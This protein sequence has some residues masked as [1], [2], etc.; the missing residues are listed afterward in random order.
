[1]RSSDDL[2]LHSN[3]S[4]E[5]DENEQHQD[6]S[7]RNAKKVRSSRACI[8]CRRMKT[9]CEIDEALGTA[10]KL[11]I[12]A[13]RQCIMQSIPRRR[14]RKTT[15]R[16]A[17]LEQ[18]INTLTALLATNDPSA[19][20][21]TTP[22]SAG[23]ASSIAIKAAG[24]D[25]S[26]AA[27]IDDAMQLGFLDWNRACKAF[28]WY[29]ENMSH[30]LP[31]VVFPATADAN[32]VKEQQPLLFFAIVTVALTAMP[33]HVNA[34]LC[35]MLTKELAL[36]IVYRGERSLELVQTLL[37]HCTWY[38]RAKNMR[39]LNFNQLAHIAC[40]MALDIGLGRRSHKGSST[41]PADPH[42][43]ESLTGRR[44]WLGCYYMGTR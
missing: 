11:C 43:L 36:R 10:C 32:V 21:N 40:T 38:A 12:R 17:D 44:A 37:V 2:D 26:P 5:S 25:P 19:A 33:V 6:G 14:K 30:Y 16:V 31:F 28:D 7:F 22:D 39:E 42:Q 27:S 29:R 23:A 18:K 3:A 35:D 13:R 4:E 1:M 15:E 41:Q 34:E 8:A 9:R 20:N 24:F